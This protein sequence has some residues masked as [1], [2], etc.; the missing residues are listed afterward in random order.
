M[1]SGATSPSVATSRAPDFEFIHI[2]KNGGTSIEQA[3]EAAGYAWGA[4][5][6][7]PACK[8]SHTLCKD[9]QLQCSLWHVPRGV[10]RTN[11][12][13][14]PRDLDGPDPYAGRRGHTQTFCV[15]RHPLERAISQ[16]IFWSMV[17]V[18]C[19]K[20]DGSCAQQQHKFDD[21][22][23]PDKLNR[24]IHERF[25][26]T[27]G[28][29]LGAVAAISGVDGP[30]TKEVKKLGGKDGEDCHWL[31]Q[32]MHVLNI[33][34]SHYGPMCDHV[35]RMESLDTDLRGLARG[36]GVHGKMHDRMHRVAKHMRSQAKARGGGEYCTM[37]IGDLDAHSRAQLGSVY[38]RDFEIFR[39]SA[40]LAETS[41]ASAAVGLQLHPDHRVGL[42]SAEL[43]DIFGLPATRHQQQAAAVATWHVLLPR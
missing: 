6:F 19:G 39:Y 38:A 37:R 32:W 7:M 18:G 36:R 4:K 3:G 33:S 12:R 17:Q 13:L 43:D 10:F 22:C 11:P 8:A 14:L 29:W 34:G 5:K 40:T 21:V 42:D 30:L 23:K 28:R 20:M 41:G 16:Y 24:Y 2:P 15:V 25:N 1:P 26:S 27:S 35:L 31:P 9:T